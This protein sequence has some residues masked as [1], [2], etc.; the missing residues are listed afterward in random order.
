MSVPEIAGELGLR[1][2]NVKSQLW[3]GVE[4]VKER[5]AWVCG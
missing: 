2:G 1:V 5:V 4:K 3:R